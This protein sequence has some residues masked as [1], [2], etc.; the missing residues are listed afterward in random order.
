MQIA[1]AFRLLLLA[2][3]VG[4]A[5]ANDAFCFNAGIQHGWDCNLS[6]PADQTFEN[7]Y[8]TLKITLAKQQDDAR[9]SEV[10]PI[11]RIGEVPLPGGERVVF[12]GRFRDSM[13]AFV[14]PTF[15]A[16]RTEQVE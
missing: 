11:E 4:G 8:H 7:E 15:S 12:L 6:R 14:C 5:S 3:L 13:K 10:L 9:L 16:F 1:V 2:T